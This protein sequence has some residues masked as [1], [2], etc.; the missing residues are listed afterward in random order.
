MKAARSARIAKAIA[1]IGEDDKED[2]D[3]AE[4][5]NEDEERRRFCFGGV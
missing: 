2:L 4:G 1:R 5:E 3:A